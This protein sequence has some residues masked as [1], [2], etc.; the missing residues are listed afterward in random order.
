V[1]DVQQVIN[2][3][4]A[5]PSPLGLYV[6]AEDQHMVK[7]VLD[8]TTSGD[9]AVNDCT[10]QPLIPKGH[11]IHGRSYTAGRKPATLSNAGEEKGKEAFFHTGVLRRACYML[12]APIIRYRPKGECHECESGPVL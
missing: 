4:N 11:G 12:P 1:D 8:S 7:Q 10:I 2:F 3:V 5:R 9:A 6:L